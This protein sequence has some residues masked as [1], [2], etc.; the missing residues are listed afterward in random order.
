[1]RLLALAILL[2][3]LAGGCAAPIQYE[4][5]GQARVL[6]A[7]QNGPYNLYRDGDDTPVWSAILLKGDAVGYGRDSS[8]QLVAVADDQR[9]P[10]AEHGYRWQHVELAQPALY[11]FKPLL[12][13]GAIAVETAAKVAI[14]AVVYSPLLLLPVLAHATRGGG[15]H[16]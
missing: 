14:V 9:L 7:P 3:V 2:L 15:P 16:H 1:M 5:G 4:P 6:E 10:L 11:N 13:A 8:A 12:A